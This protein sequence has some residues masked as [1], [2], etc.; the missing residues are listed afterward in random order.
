M[1]FNT[2]HFNLTVSIYFIYFYYIKI[3]IY[4]LILFL[5]VNLMKI[6]KLLIIS[7]RRRAY[8][9]VIFTYYETLETYWSNS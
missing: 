5:F 2:K 9:I 7:D 1:F 4:I 3:I 8:A 6:I